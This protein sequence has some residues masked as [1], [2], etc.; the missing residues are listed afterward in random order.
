MAERP[1]SGS[2]GDALR[3]LLAISQP[4]REGL[5]P[6][7]RYG[8]TARE[9]MHL[10]GAQGASLHWRVPGTAGPVLLASEGILASEGGP[11]SGQAQV[12]PGESVPGPDEAI[13]VPVPL[14]DAR[15]SAAMGVAADQRGLR[16]LLLLPLGHGSQPLGRLTLGWTTP[17]TPE[18]APD[19]ALARLVADHVT[20]ALMQA[21]A[22]ADATGL[23]A[24]RLRQ[25]EEA[26]QSLSSA[27]AELRQADRLK[28]DF[29]SAVSHEFRT[30]LTTILGFSE[31]LD[32]GVAGPLSP[33]QRRFVG[34]ITQAGLHLS[35]LV[36]DLLDYAR[37]EAGHFQVE[38]RAVEVSAIAADVV[39]SLETQ[40]AASGLRLL[41]AHEEG[42]PPVAADARRLRQVLMNLISNA[43]K[44]TRPGGE[45][46][47]RILPA[48]HARAVRFEVV[49]TGIGIDPV[50]HPFIFRKFYR[51]TGGAHAP[52]QGTGL[53]LAI[54]RE[55]V[56]VQ[57]GAIGFESTPGRGSTFW[58]EL[59]VAAGE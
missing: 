52:V 4:A 38:L 22:L 46:L 19:R 17:L 31:F 1:T 6:G 35:S 25:L 9:V 24:D 5:T 43:L 10:F 37:M 29:L 27:L 48:Q 11:A 57:G 54:T 7:E 56:S 59:L 47:V 21:R 3:A 36:D 23:A 20:L 44:F 14:G 41:L 12:L 34:H 42:L 2:A 26:S 33:E 30:P 50:H 15:W 40:A 13:L 32:E 51:V 39:A 18:Q 58:F 16:T 45:V 49:D 28:G 53:G 8:L 55:L